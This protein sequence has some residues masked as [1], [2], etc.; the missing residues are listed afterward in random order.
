[1]KKS[2]E[3]TDQKSCMSRA[4]DDEMV[5]VLLARDWAS[6]ATIRFWIAERIR[7]GKN[8]PGDPQIIEAEKCAE[9]M[10]EDDVL[11]C[12]VCLLGIREPTS[13]KE[14]DPCPGGCV[15]VDGVTVKLGIP[16]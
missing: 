14:G 12:P 1:M 9:A 3:L 10:E 15:G 6:P 11:T 7:I 4:K 2:K 8:K 16:W 5:F 13:L